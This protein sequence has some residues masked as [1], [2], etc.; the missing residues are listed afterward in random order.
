MPVNA[1]C[2][3]GKDTRHVRA[4]KVC[5]AVLLFLVLQEIALRLVFPVPEVLNFNRIKYIKDSPI[6][7]LNQGQSLGHLALW[8]WS[9]PDGAAFVRYMNLYGFQG[10]TWPKRKRPGRLRIAFFGDSFTEGLGAAADE[11]IPT[12]FARLAREQG[13]DV[14]AMNLGVAGF[15]PQSYLPVIRDVVSLFEP[16][17]AVLIIY[18]NDLY[19]E[20]D[21]APLLEPPLDPEWPNPLQPRLLY[22][23]RKIAQGERVPG[24]WHQSPGRSPK[25]RDVDSWFN[26]EPRLA[27]AIDK[28]VDP[29]IAAAMKAGRANPYLFNH[30]PRSA[31]YLPR[32]VELRPLISALKQFFQAHSTQLWIAYLPSLNQVSDAYWPYQLKVSA[33]TTTQSLMGDEFQRQARDLIRT[34]EELDVP[35]LDLTSSLRRAEGQGRRLYWPYDCHMNGQGYMLVTQLLFEWWV[36]QAR[37]RNR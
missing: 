20:P 1:Q 32:K 33:P 3:S 35:C 24:R 5:L 13:L 36:A 12:S 2:G 37:E 23:C 31:K 4:R 29:E 8:W 9:E 10:H 22:V 15:G 27:A 26:A 34:C 19:H 14:E 16:D 11:A 18:M 25:P 17:H 21:P 30:L 28:F 7:Q 6:F